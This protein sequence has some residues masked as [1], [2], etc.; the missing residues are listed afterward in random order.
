MPRLLLALLLLVPLAHA[1]AAEPLDGAVAAYQRGDYPQALPVLRAQAEAGDPVAQVYMG[2]AYYNGHGVAEDDAVSLDWFRRS[3]EQGYAE[4]QFQLG[5][6]Y[7]YG[8][9]VPAAELDPEG[10]AA[11]WF[12]EA[13]VQGHAEAQFN[14]G[15]LLLAGSGVERDEAE[16]MRWIELAAQNGSAGAQRFTGT[17]K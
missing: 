9:G 11:R 1:L 7:V 10:Q 15:L 16:A 4:G 14:L 5:Y 12:H 6:M 17:F 3:A 2:L 13:A 8:F